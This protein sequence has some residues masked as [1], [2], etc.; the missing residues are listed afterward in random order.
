MALVLANLWPIYG[1]L[2]LDWDVF[3][4]VLLFWLENVIV[5]VLNLARII[6]SRP[7]DP[8][9]HFTKLL[10][11]PFFAV[12]YGM[13]T[14]VHGVFVFALFG[15]A[16]P[17]AGV[18]DVSAVTRVV[19]RYELGIPVALL[20]ASH[21]FSFIVNYIGG[22]EYREIDVKRLMSQPYTR[23]V[24]LHLTIIGGGFLMMA[25]SSPAAG[26]VLLVALKIGVDLLAHAHE[27]D[28]ATRRGSAAA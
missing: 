19:A 22:G 3:P 12:H 20:A 17:M 9:H 5:G 24:V 25:L 21:L 23:V 26:L 28:G 18:T 16:E 1:A 7:S 2:A 27:H 13:F 15:G 14:F 10:A 11:I 8:G 4:I 6:A